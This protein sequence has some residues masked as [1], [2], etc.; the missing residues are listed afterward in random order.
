MIVK[1]IF[2]SKLTLSQNKKLNTSFEAKDIITDININPVTLA[3]MLGIILDN[4]IEAALDS[5]ERVLMIA[6]YELNQSVY[7]IVTNSID[8]VPKSIKLLEK[9]GF[10]TKG[11]NRGM[12]LSNLREMVNKLPNIYLDTIYY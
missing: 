10:S 11:K 1:S 7:I 4:A 9:N 12:G 6:I 3:R 8:E 5:E 2:A